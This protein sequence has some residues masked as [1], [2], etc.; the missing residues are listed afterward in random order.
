M[1][2]VKV[3]GSFRVLLNTLY[4]I[5]TEAQCVRALMRFLLNANKNLG[6]HVG[7][8]HSMH[9][10]QNRSEEHSNLC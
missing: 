5:A 1:F 10:Q 8:L 9:Q 7:C 4:S 3:N 6:C 2:A